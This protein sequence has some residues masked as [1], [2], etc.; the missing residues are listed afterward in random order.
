MS[1]QKNN[2]AFV[3]PGQ[4]SQY[5]GM[6]SEL[7]MVYPTVKETFEQ[8]S[9]VLDFDLWKLVQQGEPEALNQTQNT[10]PAMLAADV[11]M[12]RVWNEQTK[13]QPAWVA[14]H[15]LGEYSAL[16]CSSGL[17]FD[18]GIAL[19]AERG[20]LMQE[21]VPVGTGAMAAIIGLDDDKVI[22]VCTDSAENDIVAAVNFNAPGQVVIAGHD[23][24]VERA[25]VAAKE[26]GA[27]KVLKLSVSV[28]S[29]CQLMESAAEKLAINLQAVDVTLPEMKLVH[30]VDVM[31]HTSVDQ[32]KNVL[33]EQ[34]FKPVK[35]VDT[36][37]Y[38]QNQDVTDFVECG[39]GKV[40]M[41][42]NKRIAKGANHMTMYDSATLD[43]VLEQ[44]N[45]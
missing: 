11:A 16:V 42:L 6:M 23:A 34:L 40:L 26:M 8:A 25:M 33:K 27:K 10:Q 14:G 7:A 45:G 38:I 30:N 41:S 43:K 13:I 28:P 35:W 18:D 9:N 29:H 12:W 37:K 24:A 3:F 21:A 36:I 31:V 20:R 44:L 19:V 2:L 17:S 32:I 22:Q 39:P 15:S 5:I 4:G 1:E